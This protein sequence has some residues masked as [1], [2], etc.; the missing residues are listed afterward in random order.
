MR[1]ICR[2]A[3]VIAGQSPTTGGIARSDRASGKGVAGTGCR[4]RNGVRRAIRAPA[5]G[6][7]RQGA[8]GRISIRGADRDPACRTA[9]WRWR[10]GLLGRGGQ[11]VRRFRRTSLA[12]DQRT[13]R[14]G[15]AR[16]LL[17]CR[18]AD[19]R[20]GPVFPAS[21]AYAAVAGGPL[22]GGGGGRFGRCGAGRARSVRQPASSGAG[23]NTATACAGPCKRPSAGAFATGRAAGGH[24]GPAAPANCPGRRGGRIGPCPYRPARRAAG[25]RC[26]GGKI[27]V[28]PARQ[29][30]TGV[31]PG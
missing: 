13:A 12:V 23:R 17:C 29:I 4:K 21:G 24:R 14:Q 28:G 6:F 20:A 1:P 2:D 16:R 31:E 30:S 11:P 9:R 8:R 19:I 22:G 15:G 5:R 25:L 7:G 10:G 27:G 3:T 18:P 26:R